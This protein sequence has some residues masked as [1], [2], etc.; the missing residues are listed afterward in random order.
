MNAILTYIENLFQA[1]NDTPET[2]RAKQ[3]LTQIMED[4][5]LELKAGGA[6][7]N[8]AIG[9]VIADFG[10]LNELAD[11]LGIR[12]TIDQQ[13]SQKARL[14]VVDSPTGDDFMAKRNHAGCMIGLGVM[15]LI[16]SPIV[17]IILDTL[18]KSN[19]SIPKSSVEFIGTTILL[20][21]CAAAVVL[22]IIHGMSLGR[23]GSYETVIVR[24]DP[25]YNERLRREKA[26]GSSAYTAKLA[27][28][29]GMLILSPLV[30]VGAEALF[31]E[32]PVA[33]II[34]TC[35][36]LLLVALAI[37]MFISAT[38]VRGS[39][40]ILLS[41]G[42]YDPAAK[43]SASKVERF[44]GA[45]WTLAM[46]VYLAWSFISSNWGFTWI[47]WPIAWVLYNLL[48]QLVRAM[49]IKDR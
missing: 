16:T 35:V 4:K 5:Y 25:A 44:A 26:A 47:V 2:R 46:L 23:T 27:L 9:R 8:E 7:E 17:L 29:V 40:D 43:K 6:S 10:D 1:L 11:E 28:G 32:N 36:L 13:D 39:Y 12:D 41:E 20:M 49:L 21:M 31:P 24:L 38:F 33:T 30:L 14:V 18:S 45:Y 48:E 15:M 42:E 37:Y 3:E 19:D 22:F 34:G